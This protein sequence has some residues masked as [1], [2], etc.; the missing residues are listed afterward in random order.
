MKIVDRKTFLSLPGEVLF[1]RYEPC[2]FDPLEIKGQ[3][4]ENDFLTTRI[5]DAI[6]CI[7][8]SEFIDFLDCAEETGISLPL[9][10]E[11]TERD[12][13]HDDDQLYA[14]WEPKDVIQLIERLKRLI[15]SS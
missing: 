10:F 5:N 2:V 9:N 14:V 7:D 1:S 15:P 6:D 13:C 4:L 12:G 8:S 11:S 3:T